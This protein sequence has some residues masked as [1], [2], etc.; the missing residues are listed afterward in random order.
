MIHCLGTVPS[1]SRSQFCSRSLP[2]GRHFLLY[3]P[4]AGLIRGGHPPDPVSFN[5]PIVSNIRFPRF[6]SMYSHFIRPE[7]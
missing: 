3:T 5:L 7:P 6:T 1:W 4:G 2:F